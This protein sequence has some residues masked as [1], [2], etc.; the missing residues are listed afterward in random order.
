MS[1]TNNPSKLTLLKRLNALEQARIALDKRSK[2]RRLTPGE[3]AC[4]T[5][6]GDGVLMLP[7]S[8]PGAPTMRQCPE[9]DGT[10]IVSC[11]HSDGSECG[12]CNACGAEIDWISRTFKETEH[13]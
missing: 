9:C 7:D 13:D 6:G 8:V 5:C 1:N 10:G 3:L 11:D 12:I 4:D 2:H